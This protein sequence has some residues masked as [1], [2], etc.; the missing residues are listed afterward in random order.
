M[1]LKKIPNS[2]LVSPG[3]SSN[4]ILDGDAESGITN[5]IEGS[6]AAATRPAGTFTASSGAGALAI[7]TSTTT[8]INGVTS[9]LI[10]KSS[11]A[12]RQGRAVERTITL[13]QEY[14]TKV[15]QMR[16]KFN[17]VS[18]TF[19]AGTN[20]TSPTDSSM[21]FYI[22]QFNG[23]TWSYTEPGNFKCL[24]NGTI[25]DYVEGTFQ[26]NS[27]TTQ[28]KLIAYV[29]ETANSAWVLKCEFGISPSAYVYGTPV[30][31]WQTYSLS[32][33][34]T[35]TNP[36]KGSILLDTAKW[37]R[38][39][40]SMEIVY[41]FYQNS[42][43]TAGSGDYLFSIPSGYTIDSTKIVVGADK[44]T[45]N[46]GSANGYSAGAYIG[47][48]YPYN[49]TKL[50]VA[51]MSE[52]VALGTL[53]STNLPLTG[54]PLTINF[55]AKIPILGW[56]SSIQVSDG[57][58]GRQVVAAMIVTTAT[59]NIA[60]NSSTVLK[61]FTSND[62]VNGLDSTNGTY[63]IKTAGYYQ[64]SAELTFASSAN[65]AGAQMSISK[66]VNGSIV[67]EILSYSNGTYTE[68]YAIKGTYPVKFH[69]AGDV[70]TFEGYQVS[71]VTKTVYNGYVSIFKVTGSQTI[72][73]SESI[74]VKYFGTTF[75]GANGII[76]LT[77][78]VV[79]SHGAYNTSTGVYTFVAA[80]VYDVS[81]FIQ[82]PATAFAVNGYL[83]A[84]AS[85]NG[86]GSSGAIIGGS[87]AETTA[88]INRYATGS[89]IIKVNAGDTFSLYQNSSVSIAPISV[90]FSL[91]KVGN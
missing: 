82:S 84:Y 50:G 79:D 2:M 36:T 43:G 12:S 45:T 8:P 22:G 89:T 21:I 26:V 47:F 40:D 32:I 18:G 34:G 68:R 44:N 29:A 1:A 87:R 91:K 69:N 73:A 10:T 54:N 62:T 5:Y 30:T 52:V 70:I 31:D 56:S 88:A 38:V 42:A 33:T 46:C 17:V 13:D 11:G 63:T 14:R 78:K 64:M 80:G 57:Y 9:F 35:T 83:E 66:K 19:V 53:G 23:T 41:S 81:A 28:I 65:T 24:S 6:Y 71:G 75:S 4:L 16:V 27:D 51:V 59:G 3:G 90:T 37:R 85:V 55:T 15:L 86:S 60:N 48:V 72:S 7:S 67:D 20:G 61:G 76:I 49:I 25:T 77:N 58:D 74:N 39:G